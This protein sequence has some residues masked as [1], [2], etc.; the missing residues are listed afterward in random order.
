MFTDLPEIPL[1]GLFQEIEYPDEKPPLRWLTLKS[2][3]EIL[4][5]GER[6]IQIHTKN[7]KLERKY[8]TVK[9]HRRVYYSNHSVYKLKIHLEGI[10]ERALYKEDPEDENEED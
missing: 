1:E 10:R 5:I 8:K 9:G 3:K 7:G 6:S 2:T 4:G